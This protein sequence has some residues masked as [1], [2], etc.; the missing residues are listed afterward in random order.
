MPLFRQTWGYDP[1]QKRTVF[2]LPLNGYNPLLER[3]VWF[4]I[5][6]FSLQVLYSRHTSLNFTT[7]T[8]SHRA[9]NKLPIVPLCNFSASELSPKKSIRSLLDR[10]NLRHFCVIFGFPY[11]YQFTVGSTAFVIFFFFEIYFFSL[12]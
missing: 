11:I 4:N 12:S 7:V 1:K 6:G 10:N 9:R 2:K 3:T 8:L 5:Q